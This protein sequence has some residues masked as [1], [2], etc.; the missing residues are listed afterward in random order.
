MAVEAVHLLVNFLKTGEVR[1]AVNMAAIDPKTL[2]ALRG[3]LMLAHRLGRLLAQWHTGQ[4]SSCRL[5]YRGDLLIKEAK[6]L[7]AAF[8]AGLMEGALEEEVNIVNSE[9]LFRERGVEL[10]EESSSETGA[11]GS[12]ICAES[13]H[14]R[15]HVCRG[16]HAVWE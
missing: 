11:F 12:P 2:S 10:I 5:N 3:Y 6:L 7:T 4:L 13:G 9:V 1:H 16:G 15:G 8:C 14:Q